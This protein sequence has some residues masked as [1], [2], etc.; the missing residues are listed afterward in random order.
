[1]NAPPHSFPDRVFPK[2]RRDPSSSKFQIQH[3]G[4]QTT[5]DRVLVAMKAALK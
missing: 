2:T 3:S 4:W 1:M 5:R